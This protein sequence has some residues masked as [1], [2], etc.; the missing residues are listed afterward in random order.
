V[1]AVE[2]SGGDG[3]D[4]VEVGEDGDKVVDV[5]WALG[6][7]GDLDD[8]FSDGTGFASVTA[9]VAASG[10]GFVAGAGDGEVADCEAVTD[11][12]SS[13]PRCRLPA[14]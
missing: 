12:T 6:G 1:L 9:L 10:F 5:S 4:V 2:V 8:V 7:H 14:G 3:D 11:G 13:T